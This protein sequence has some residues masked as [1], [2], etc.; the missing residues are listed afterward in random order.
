MKLFNIEDT[1]F[2]E[3]IENAR[4]IAKATMN[5]ENECVDEAHMNKEEDHFKD[6]AVHV[7]KDEKIKEQ[8]EITF[9]IKL[10]ETKL[11]AKIQNDVSQALGKNKLRKKVKPKQDVFT[12]HSDDYVT[13]FNIINEASLVEGQRCFVTMMEIKDK[14]GMPELQQEMDLDD[15]T[16]GFSSINQ[17]MSDDDPVS[18]F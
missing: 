2:F 12:L 3:E 16:E 5:E 17:W 7:N 14:S 15:N 4:N 13:Q 18:Y 10:P 6:E 1:G 9:K 8:S 11:C